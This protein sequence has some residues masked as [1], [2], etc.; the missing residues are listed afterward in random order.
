MTAARHER[1]QPLV[2]LGGGLVGDLAGFTAA[3]YRRGVPL[4]QCPTTL[5]AMAD[6]SIG[7]KTGVNI[8]LGGEGG[9]KKNMAGAFHQPALVL[10]DPD[11]LRSLAPRQF[12]AGLAECVK[13]GL[14]GAAA[15]DPGL[16]RW[17]AEHLVGLLA[18]DPPCV[19]ELVARNIAVKAAIASPDERE[20]RP[21][22]GRIL[23]NLGH[24]FAHAIE[25]LP[26]L[27][28][29]G[30]PTKAPLLHGE[31]VALGLVAAAETARELD[32]C[33]AAEVD[34]LLSVLSRSGLPVEI[35]GLPPAA[36]LIE[37][38]GFDKKVAS[39]RLRLVLPTGTG[40]ATVVSNPPIAAINAGLEAIR[41]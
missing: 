21:D 23:L 34:Q 5:L 16:F 38:M 36:R 25:T 32:L 9:L 7:G 20:E 19:A 39:G 26:H 15:G 2:A 37:L 30:D 29:D 10:I 17:T 13:H 41:A 31:A 14:I 6:A 33:G 1:T 22:G 28:P 18:L 8:D 24:T 12:R 3:T 27:T 11:L 4:I 35:N 40:H